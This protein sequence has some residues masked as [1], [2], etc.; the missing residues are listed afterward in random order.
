MKIFI[1]AISVVLACGA[2][3]ALL[4]F[5]EFGQFANDVCPYGQ[6]GEKSGNH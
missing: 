3:A 5:R 1:A 4:F 6:K 2:G